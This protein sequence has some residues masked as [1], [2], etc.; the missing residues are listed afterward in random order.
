MFNA[1]FSL[2]L[3]FSLIVSDIPGQQPG[4]DP[5]EFPMLGARS[6]HDQVFNTRQLGKSNG[7]GQVMYPQPIE[8]VVYNMYAPTDLR[9]FQCTG[10]GKGPSESAQEFQ[11][12]VED[13]P[14]LPGSNNSKSSSGG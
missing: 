4:L 2:L 12:R 14:S 3:F 8:Y 9:L 10:G 11:M 5:S 13:F 6:Q 1:L 7:C